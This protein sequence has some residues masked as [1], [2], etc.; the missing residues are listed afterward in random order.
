[1]KITGQYNSQTAVSQNHACMHLE[2][3]TPSERVG[4]AVYT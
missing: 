2:S 4:C 3:N 1:M